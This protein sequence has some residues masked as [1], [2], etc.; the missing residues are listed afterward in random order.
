MKCTCEIIKIGSRKEIDRSGYNSLHLARYE[1]A[2]CLE[3]ISDDGY[4]SQRI[5]YCPFCGRDLDE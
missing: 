4:P 5:F 1:D 3:G 2:Y